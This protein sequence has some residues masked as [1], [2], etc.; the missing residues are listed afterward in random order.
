[1]V[2]WQEIKAAEDEALRVETHACLARASLRIMPGL[3]KRE[4]AAVRS[5]LLGQRTRELQALLDRLDRA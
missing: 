1:M 4:A 5:A 3:S 2:S